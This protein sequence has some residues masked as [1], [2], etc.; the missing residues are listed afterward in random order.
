MKLLVS[1]L[2]TLLSTAVGAQSVILSQSFSKL[3]QGDGNFGPM[4]SLPAFTDW[5]F[6]DYCYAM[7]DDYMFV[8][9]GDDPEKNLGK[10]TTPALGIYG[11]ATLLIKTKRSSSGY[12]P[13]FSV[14]VT[15]GEVVGTTVY[16]IAAGSEYRPSAILL[17]NLTPNSKI[18]IEGTYGK[19]YLNTIKVFS[20]DDAIFYES[21]DYMSGR[22]LGEFYFVLDESKKATANLCDNSEGAVLINI[23]QSRKNIFIRYYGESTASSY[24]MPTVPL[25]EPCSALLSFRIGHLNQDDNYLSLSCSDI[26]SDIDMTLYNPSQSPTYEESLRIDLDKDIHSQW[27]DK[28]VIIRNMNSSTI[29]TYEGYGVNLNDIL[30]RPLTVLDEAS[31]IEVSTTKYCSVELIRK[32]TPNTWCP[33][34]L[35]F[36]VTQSQMEDAMET[37]CELRTLTDIRG[38][39]FIFDKVTS[40]SAGTPFLIKVNTL[41]ENPVFTGVT[42]VDTPAATATGSAMGYSFVGTYSPVSLNTNGTHLFLDKE[43][44]LCQP[45]LEEGYNRL[46]GLRAYFVVPEPSKARVFISDATAG[47]SHINQT[48]IIRYDTYDL[49]GRH[50]ETSNSKGL[51]IQNGRKFLAR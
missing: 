48:P 41:V 40:V 42:V 45:D 23:Y 9:N 37:T 29:L 15:D 3:Y 44:N 12:V 16:E 47:V 21:F 4:K 33:L 18:I 25:E 11:N 36:N 8:G 27:I 46:N 1:V 19:F 38:G 28:S 49:N 34:C 35:P 43:G 24:V 6:N 22:D 14:S 32:L 26:T 7:K 31:N 13:K 51:H 10:V 50:I 17:K 2:F 5:E 30:V 39:V 20:I